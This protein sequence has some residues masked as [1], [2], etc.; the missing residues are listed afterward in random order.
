MLATAYC[1]FCQF[2][3]KMFFDDCPGFPSTEVVCETNRRRFCCWLNGADHAE[4]GGFSGRRPLDQLDWKYTVSS[5][6]GCVHGAICSRFDKNAA[7][8]VC[9]MK[10]DVMPDFLLR[11]H[12]DK[13]AQFPH[14]APSS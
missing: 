13:T 12:V 8:L 9:F 6:S 14:V 2:L 3:L 7:T 5:I 11:Y 10:P 1:P 4:L